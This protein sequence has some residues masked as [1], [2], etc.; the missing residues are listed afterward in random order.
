M[1]FEK[2]ENIFES[3][4]ERNFYMK[5][6]AGYF[7]NELIPGS[8]KRLSQFW[9]ILLASWRNIPKAQENVD[10]KDI[11]RSDKE[12]LVINNGEISVVTEPNNMNPDFVHVSFDNHAYTED[13]GEFADVLIYDHKTLATAVAL[14]VKYKTNYDIQKDVCR[15]ANRIKWI[16]MRL[17]KTLFIP[18]L[19]LTKHKWDKS[20]HQREAYI[21][22]NIILWD[23]L[24]AVCEKE[25][26]KNYFE[27]QL[28][29]PQK[30]RYE[31]T[32]NKWVRKSK[33]L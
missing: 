18:C 17:T 1:L 30:P 4:K 10:Y 23:D 27:Y 2:G 11:L 13:N 19:L 20:S 16:S 3:E 24:V 29:L 26:I 14:E 31:F 6:F 15:N 25:E 28:R 32:N 9:D 7:L 22:C 5:F 8:A 12:V 33:V 21:G